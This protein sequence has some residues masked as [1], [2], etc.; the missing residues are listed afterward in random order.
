VHQHH[1]NGS[2]GCENNARSQVM[3]IASNNRLST[4]IGGLLR[5]R[6]GTEAIQT[7]TSNYR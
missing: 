4:V 2:G 6:A 5:M 7:S 3:P 1:L